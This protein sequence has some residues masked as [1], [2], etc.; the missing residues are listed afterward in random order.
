MSF[1]PPKCD[2]CGDALNRISNINPNLTCVNNDCKQEFNLIRVTNV[3]KIK[4]EV[5]K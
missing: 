5:I 2:K 4:A 1:I 3:T